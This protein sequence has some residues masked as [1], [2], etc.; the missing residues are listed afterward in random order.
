MLRDSKA[1]GPHEGAALHWQVGQGPNADWA[2][3]EGDWKLIGN[4]RDTS[5][6]D[7]PS[8]RVSMFLANLRDDPGETRRA[9]GLYAALLA[10][11]QAAG[12]QPYRAG[13]LAWQ[14][15]H[16]ARS[17]PFTG[18]WVLGRTAEK[19]EWHDLHE[20]CLAAAAGLAALAAVA[21]FSP[22][23]NPCRKSSVKTP[24]NTIKIFF[25]LS[26]LLKKK[27]AA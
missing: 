17:F 1:P 22:T 20:A 13:L 18:G 24:I 25:M 12:Y 7:G 16:A 4:T 6:G 9:E 27:G 3:R 21:A 5:L 8:K 10:D 26:F 23:I 19:S 14:D 15:V 2:V 11:M